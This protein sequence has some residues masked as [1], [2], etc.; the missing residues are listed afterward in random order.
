MADNT[1]IQFNNIVQNQMPAYVRNEYPLVSEFLKSY[2]Q[3]QEY[4]GGPVDLIQNIDKYTKINKLSN[5]VD[6]VGLGSDITFSEDTI[7]VDMTSFPS[8][9][10]GFPDNWGLIKIDDEIITY[11]N[12]TATSFTGC[13]RGFSGIT[14]YR[15]ETKPDELTFNTSNAASHT[16]YAYNS[17]GK[18]ITTGSRIENLS[19]LFLNEFL[20]KTKHQL[21]PGLEDRKLSTDLDQELFIK[22]AKDFYLSKGTDRSFEILFKALYDEDVKIVKPRDFLF[23]PSNAHYIVENVLV[24]EALEGDPLN[25]ENQTLFQ[26]KYNTQ[27]EKAYAPISSIEKV[28]PGIGGTYYKIGLDAG[29]N[30]DV[31]VQGA[32]YGAFSVHAKT[33]NIG[34]VSSGSTFF[35]VDSTVGFPTAGELS[36]T[37]NDYSA[38]IV[39]YTSKSLTQFFGCSN[40]TGIIPTASNIGINTY[41]FGASSVGVGTTVIKIRINNV[42]SDLSYPSDTYY[43]AK[44]DTVKIKT[45][46]VSDKTYKA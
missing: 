26:N 24:V 28:T 18:L 3:G 7:S 25:L 1:R 12:K 22:Q 39:S 31:R 36:V 16:G 23:T 29:Y 15:T 37:Y 38:G 34:E 6:H 5:L 14:T 46:G 8:G 10:E 40:L 17:T 11:T 13:V 20:L 30:R 43:Y 19:S 32:V 45:L 21:L 35:N 27:Y 42:L 2:Y 44:D 4:Q 33:R 9:T 41:A